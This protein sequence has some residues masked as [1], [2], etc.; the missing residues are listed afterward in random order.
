M[1][2]ERVS[3]HK[4]SYVTSDMEPGDLLRTKHSQWSMDSANLL[5]SCAQYLFTVTL[6]ILTLDVFILDTAYHYEI[7][8][9]TASGWFENMRI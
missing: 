3:D 9:G 5:G 4:C 8:F 1:V 7:K 6:Q 2:L